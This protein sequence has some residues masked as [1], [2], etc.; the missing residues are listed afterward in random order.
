MCPYIRQLTISKTLLKVDWSIGFSN[1]NQSESAIQHWPM[2]QKVFQILRLSALSLFLQPH[3]SWAKKRVSKQKESK[4]LYWSHFSSLFAL[5]LSQT[6]RLERTG[7]KR[8][9]EL[10]SF[11]LSII[12][13]VDGENKSCISCH[14]LIHPFTGSFHIQGGCNYPLPRHHRWSSLASHHF[15]RA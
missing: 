9:A 1:L 8:L 3:F 13:A 5:P 14:S 11:N 12:M 10:G 6:A 2:T 7:T 4:S 15:A